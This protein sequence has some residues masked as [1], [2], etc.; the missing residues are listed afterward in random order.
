LTV[1]FKNCY[2]Q[3]MKLSLYLSITAAIAILFGLVF[4]LLP[5]QGVAGLGMS[6]NPGVLALTRSMGCLLLGLGIINWSARNE[7]NSSLL[8]GV[9]LANLIVQIIETLLSLQDIY[10]GVVSSI[11]WGGEILHI[12]L[13]LGF[14]YYLTK[15]SGQR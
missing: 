6:A 10:S 3:G 12:I 5:D 7:K 14:L 13:A 1:E 4:L 2:G 9:L 11:D 15:S 8:K